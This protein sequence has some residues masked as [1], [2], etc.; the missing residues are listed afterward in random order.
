MTFEY[1]HVAPFTIGGAPSTP[2]LP[3]FEGFDERV[4]PIAGSPPNSLDDLETD[5]FDINADGLPDVVDTDP[6]LYNGS[7]GLFL[8]GALGTPNAFGPAQ[9]MAVNGVGGDNAS[10]LTLDNLNVSALDLDGDGIINLMHMPAVLTYSVYAPVFANGAWAWQGRAITTASGQS[11]KIDFTRHAPDTRVMDVNGDGLVDVVYSSGTEYQTF[12]SLGRFPQGYGQYGSATLT[13]PTTSSISNEPVTS[14]LPWSAAP[15]LLSDS[16]TRVADMNGDGLPDLVRVRAG[17]VRYWPGRGNGYWGTGNPTSCPAGTF[18]QGQ[19]VVMTTSPQF[20]VVQGASLLLDDVN[21]DGLDDLVKVE[22]NA[23]SIYLNVD[24]VGW[25][26]RHLISN[27]PPRPATTDRVRLVDINGSGTRDIL[28]GDG[29]SYKYIDLQG[30]ARPWV[31]THM[32]N[33]LGKT[34]DITYSTSTAMM[35]AAQAAGQP[36]Q[37][38]APMPVHVVASMTHSDNLPLAGHGATSYVTQYT[39][40]DPVYDGRQRE[41]RGFGSVST[42]TVGDTNSP[43]SNVDSR[44]LLGQCIQEAGSANNCTIDE[45]WA[46]NPREALKGFPTLSES[47]D[48]G[49]T[50]VSTAHQTA[51]LRV[52][53]E[54]LDGR[55]VRVAFPSTSDSFSYDTSPFVPVVPGSTTAGES[56][57]DVELEASPGAIVADTTSSVAVRGQGFAHVRST[58]SPDFFGNVTESVSLGCVE[59]CASA[60]EAITQYKEYAV[61]YPFG[62][63]SGWMWRPIYGATGCP[64]STIAQAK[65]ITSAAISRARSRSIASTRIPRKASRRL[66]PRRPRTARGATTSSSRTSAVTPSVTRQSCLVPGP[67]RTAAVSR[68]TTRRTPSSS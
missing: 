15:I 24:G 30:G 44:F 45:M 20:G 6:V 52:L 2:D 11:S 34:T 13:S 4:I 59:G 22:F 10:T 38:V 26:E 23:V 32:A 25:T 12:F 61:G 39:Y 49:S 53:Y 5:L 3:G 47:R 33:G 64:S 55:Q 36:W 42:R 60:D 51:R 50:Y 54:G 16:D 7:H 57:T 46:D 35:L 37:S 56:M 17:D 41:F 1:Q 58:T 40:R 43:T 8:N 14:C 28:W 27:S 66:R 29:N 21:G 68:A 18:G 63:P 31:L 48:D 65:S 67:Q 9:L 19:E 62:D